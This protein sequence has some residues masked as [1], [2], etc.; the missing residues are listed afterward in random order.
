MPE[1]QRKSVC[2]NEEINYIQ[3]DS[4]LPRFL[5]SVPS[6]DPASPGFCGIP[7]YSPTQFFSFSFAI[8]SALLATKQRVT[9][10]SLLN[11]IR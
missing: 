2:R 1:R 6:R 5:S 3:K 8:S 4:I 9:K 10:I 7:Q 11:Q